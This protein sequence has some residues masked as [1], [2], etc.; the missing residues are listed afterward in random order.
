MQNK[1]SETLR[2]IIL[3]CYVGFSVVIYIS[4]L[5]QRNTPVALILLVFLGCLVLVGFKLTERKYK[6]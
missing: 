5:I 3:A 2:W 4:H 1:L 6:E